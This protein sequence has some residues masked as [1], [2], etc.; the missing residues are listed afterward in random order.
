MEGEWNRKE[1][2]ASAIIG[3]IATIFLVSVLVTP[4]S[5]NLAKA[6][7]NAAIAFNG[8]AFALSPKVLFEKVS[9]KN[10]KENSWVVFG[11]SAVLLLLGEVFM[12][13]AGICWLLGRTG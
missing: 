5:G 7:W 8:F 10:L 6:W 1:K 12:V 13:F 2:L 4:I 3:S 11:A 9:L